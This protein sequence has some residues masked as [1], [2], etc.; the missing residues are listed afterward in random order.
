MGS[1]LGL[2]G[3]FSKGENVLITAL[4][5]VLVLALFS[6]NILSGLYNSSSVDDSSGNQNDDSTSQTGNNSDGLQENGI[7]VSP[8]LGLSV[9]PQSPLAGDRLTFTAYSNDMDSV[10]YMEVW[11]K[12]FGNWKVTTCYSS[13]CLFVLDS[14]SEGTHYYKARA[15]G[16]N[17]AITVV[18]PSE[19]SELVVSPRSTVRDTLGPSVNVSIDPFNPK[20]GD[21][22]VI[23][24]LASDSSSVGETAIYVDGVLVKVCNQPV[25]VSNCFYSTVFSSVGTH[26]YY[27]SAADTLG[28]TTDSQ[29][30]S[31]F[32]Q[33]V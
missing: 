10:D 19:S 24:V 23:T 33:S 16:K 32:V 25:K 1:E 21:S 22:V 5:V 6:G 11:W 30:E 12:Q 13:P 4:V 20:I 2:V 17:G 31:F 7:P 29:P 9:S 8:S 28:N 14:A 3:F 18:P 27:A 15:V 26:A